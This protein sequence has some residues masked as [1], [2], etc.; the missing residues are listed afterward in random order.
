M[1][2]CFL[3]LLNLSSNQWEA[4]DSKGRFGSSM[5]LKEGYYLK[6]TR[7]DLEVLHDKWQDSSFP[8]PKCIMAT[9]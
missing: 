6:T 9:S 5:L 7:I 3:W 4:S 8:M 1:K 2:D